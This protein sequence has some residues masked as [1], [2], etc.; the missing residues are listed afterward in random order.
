VIE[1]IPLYIP[2]QQNYK[3]T[4]KFTIRCL[5]ALYVIIDKDKNGHI[6]EK[7]YMERLWSIISG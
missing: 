4:F 7:I 6:K 5:I 2:V 1:I 3:F